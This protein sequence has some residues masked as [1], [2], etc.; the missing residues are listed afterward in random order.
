MVGHT[1]GP[2]N[3]RELPEK[4]ETTYYVSYWVD[5]PGLAPIADVKLNGDMAL[6]NARLIAAAPEMLE[7][8]ELAKAMGFGGEPPRECYEVFG[9][10]ALDCQC[11]LAIVEAAIFKA[12]GGE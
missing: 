10:G 8:L 3:Y 5:G 11:G 9:N 1:Q 4:D 12:K 7:A 6:A 2:W